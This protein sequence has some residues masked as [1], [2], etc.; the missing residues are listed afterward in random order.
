MYERG[1][2][3]V[4]DLGELPS[5][6]K[7]EKEDSKDEPWTRLNDLSMFA[8]CGFGQFNETLAIG[9]YSKKKKGYCAAPRVDGKG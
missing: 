4:S 8:H 9:V 2:G 7:A 6:I 5:L 1:M 3:E